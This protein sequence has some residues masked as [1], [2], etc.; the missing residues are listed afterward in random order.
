ML[1]KAD[2]YPIHQTPDPV[3]FAM[4]DRNFYDRY[5]FSGHSEDGEVYFAAALGVYPNLNIMDAAFG[6]RI[7][8]TQ[9][10]IHASR[11]LGMERMDTQVGP[12]RVEVLEPLKCLRVRVE[13]AEGRL[14]ADL[15]FTGRH[16]PIEEPRHT[17]RH[18]PRVIMDL[19]RMTQLG[20]Y[21]GWIRA[22]GREFQAGGDA[23]LL[24]GVRDRSWGVRAV[25]A[26]DPQPMVPETTNQFH[27][28]WMP[29]HFEDRTLLFYRNEDSDG[30]V[31]NSGMLL[32]DDNGQA[33][34]L[35]DERIEAELHPG[36][37]WPCSAEV[38][39]CDDAGGR[40]QLSVETGERFYLCG[41][42]Y[43]H[44]DWAPGLNKGPLAV[45][46]DE[47]A[48]CA[49]QPYRPPYI[50]VQAFARLTLE[51]P[52]GVVRRGIGALETFSIGPNSARNFHGLFDPA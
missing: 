9:Y 35:R 3:A 28:Y 12:I 2:D 52:D 42:G 4:S 43:S 45:G 14:S 49:E 39:A 15:T 1:S 13:D 26:Q 36:S 29:A 20:S 30:A 10:N 51:A 16:A 11:H 17:R 23:P 48:V 24:S 50:H 8:T 21:S 27:W 22:G 32:V 7:G 19:T 33:T 6:V 5:F 41:V 46:Y 44:P 25:G 38:T 40:Y 37:R 18:G 47:I 34:P 31:W